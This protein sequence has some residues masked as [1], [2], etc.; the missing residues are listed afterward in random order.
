MVVLNRHL[1]DGSCPLSRRG[2]VYAVAAIGSFPNWISR[3]ALATARPFVCVDAT[4]EESRIWTP[5]RVVPL[6][7]LLPGAGGPG[8]RKR[9]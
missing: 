8:E 6:E 4:S 3:C 2:Q 7:N 9:S 5:H 1:V